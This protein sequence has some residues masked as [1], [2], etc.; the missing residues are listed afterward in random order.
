MWG[1]LG[2][3]NRIYIPLSILTTL[4]VLSPLP[5]ARADSAPAGIPESLRKCVDEP[6]DTRR[7]ACFDREMD[8]L[9]KETVSAPVSAPVA[10]PVET[11][12]QEEKFGIVERSEDKK[13]LT[14][15]QATVV[16][17][18]TSSNRIFTVL[19]DNDQVWRQKYAGRFLIT[20]G[21][22]VT[23]TKG[24]FG[25]YTLERGGRQTAVNRVK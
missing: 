14:E 17:V 1:K 13:E 20:T 16:K 21:D 7:L 12:E 22:V 10:D 3:M 19:L 23:I 15:I 2:V 8:R 6:D 4:L 24:N 11:A 25:G 5:V 9:G 18:A